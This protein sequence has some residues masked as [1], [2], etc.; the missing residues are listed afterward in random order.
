VIRAFEAY[1]DDLSNWYIR[2][3]RRRFWDGDEA[4]LRTLWHALAQ[5]MRAIAPV[6]PFLA[7]HLW[8]VLVRATCPDAPPSV[9]LAGWPRELEPDAS[10]LAEIV[11]VRRVVALGHQA[12]QAAG[13]K[14]QQPL[15]ALVVEGAALA[16][17]QAAEIRD[18]LRVKDVRFGAV[19]SELL[20]KPNLPVLGPKLGRELG[21]VREALRSGAFE[22]LGDGRFRAAGHELGP[23][24]VL[25]ERVGLEGWAVAADDGLTVALDTS[26]DDDLRLEAD[27][28]DLIR[29]VQVLRKESGLEVTDRIKLWIPDVRLLAFSDRIAA[30]T[31]AVSVEHGGELRLERAET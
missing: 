31:L 3:S 15:R 13:C 24:E 14:V 23:D 25:V 29:S 20:V 16:E 11:D 28:Y 1:V 9:H 10:L 17:A 22:E 19:D 27:L 18:E 6:M 5:T 4:A 2:R 7:D 8:Q 12:R 30:E 21:P 26:L